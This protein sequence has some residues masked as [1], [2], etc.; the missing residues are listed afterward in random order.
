MYKRQDEA[1]P[2][3]Q[4]LRLIYANA[5]TRTMTGAELAEQAAQVEKLLYQLKEQGYEFPGR[6]RDHVA[7]ALSLIHI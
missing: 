2:E 5:N 4:Q 7:Q 1:S 6:M 3:L